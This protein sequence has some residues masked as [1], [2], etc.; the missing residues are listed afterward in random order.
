VLIGRVLENLVCVLLAWA[1]AVFPN[2]SPIRRMLDIERKCALQV[3]LIGARKGLL[4]SM[5]TNQV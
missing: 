2:D 3:W 4:A 1:G 5:G